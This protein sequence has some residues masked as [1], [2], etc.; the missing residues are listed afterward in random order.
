MTSRQVLGFVGLGAVLAVGVSLA[1]LFWYYR[2]S[3]EYAYVDILDLGPGHNP[4]F[5]RSGL[6]SCSWRS[7]QRS[8]GGGIGVGRNWSPN[9]RLQRTPLRASLSRKPLGD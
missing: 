1:I 9:P 6:A 2:P 7:L 8:G 3:I 5:G 4:L